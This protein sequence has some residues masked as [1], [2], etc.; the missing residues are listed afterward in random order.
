[1]GAL[2]KDFVVE[3]RVRRDR[4]EL[5]LTTR[6]TPR[7]RFI[8][9]VNKEHGGM[10]DS[11]PQ[12][13]NARELDAREV[14]QL[15]SIFRTL[16]ELWM[17]EPLNNV[18]EIYDLTGGVDA[19]RGG[20]TLSTRRLDDLAVLYISDPQSFGDYFCVSVDLRTEEI[21]EALWV[22]L[23]MS[24]G[25]LLTPQEC[26]FL[27]RSL[28][29][30]GDFGV[31]GNVTQGLR[32]LVT[33]YETQI[34]LREDYYSFYVLPVDGYGHWLAFGMDATTGKIANSAAGHFEPEPPPDDDG[35][36]LG[37]LDPPTDTGGTPP[38]DP[39]MPL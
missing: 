10:Y 28:Q 36:P 15:D 18:C 6:A 1:M 22:N 38:E 35:E 3:P 2:E 30:N 12:L 11:G 19:L 39:E 16:G 33:G 23:P 9:N 24:P 13:P 21:R 20:R 17:L 34:T 4:Y 32:A 7:V 37:C 26:N 29:D 14:S 25:H 27:D 31:Y 5:R 8:Q